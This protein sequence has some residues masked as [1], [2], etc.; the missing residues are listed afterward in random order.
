MLTGDLTDLTLLAYLLKSALLL[1]ICASELDPNSN[2][3]KP[4]NRPTKHKHIRD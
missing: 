4:E 2:K 3:I 1:N